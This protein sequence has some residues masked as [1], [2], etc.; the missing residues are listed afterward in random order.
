MKRSSF[1]MRACALRDVQAVEAR[2]SHVFPRHAH[3]GY[4]IGLIVDG[5]HRSWS[6]RG[7][8]EAGP[9]SLIT[10]N[11]GEVHDGRPIGDSRAWSMLYLAP[12]LVETIVA[13]IREGSTADFEFAH[14]VIES[15]A[16]VRA[17]ELAYA[18][19]TDRCADAGRAQER[20]ILLLAGMLHRKPPSPPSASALARAK[21][22]IDE[23]PAAPI[24]LA[25]LA[26]DADLSRF[27]IVRGFAKLTGLTPH[28]YIVQRRL[29]AARAMM[30]DGGALANIAVVCGFAD[31]S[32]FNRMFVQRYGVTPGAYAEAM[33]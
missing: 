15:Q 14:P 33:R 25:A 1:T 30:A 20:L 17:F 6:G 8:V 22:R 9:G 4:G 21:A 16:Q 10:C 27:Q 12:G 26:R 19:A 31:Q 32:H 18:T 2:S 29:E 3:D 13:D 28:A 7:M 23:D 24:T 5:A 11:P